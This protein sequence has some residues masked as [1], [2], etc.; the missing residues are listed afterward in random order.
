[1]RRILPAVAFLATATVCPAPATTQALPDHL[2]EG[3]FEVLVPNLGAITVPVLVDTAQTVLIPLEPL[4][5]HVGYSVELQPGRSVWRAAEAAPENRLLLDPPRF[6]GADGRTSTLSDAAVAAVNDEVYVSTEALAT[7]LDAEVEVDWGALRVVVSRQEPPFPAQARARIEERRRR[8]FT[9]TAAGSGPVVPYEARSGGVIFDWNIGTSPTEERTL[10]RGAVG[11]AVL[12]GDLVVGGSVAMGRAP[13]RTAEVSY[14]RIFPERRWVNQL[15]LGQVVTQDMAPRSLAGV[16]V[17]NIP[18]QRDAQFAHVPVAPDIPEGWEFEVYQSGRLIGFSSAGADDAV[19]VPVR[20]GQTPLEVRMVG[21]SGQEVVSQ[22]RYMVPISHLPPERLEYSA[23]AGVC[24][25]DRCD[26]LGY[27]EVRYGL[28]RRLTVGGGFQAVSEDGQ[29]SLRPSALASFVPDRHWALEMEARAEEFV[30]ASVDRL[31][32]DGRHVGLDASLHQPVFG[33]P[34]FFLGSDTRWQIQAQAGLHP[35]H[36]SARLDGMTGK[37]AE[38]VRV[39][40]GRSIPRGFGELALEVGDFGE[41]RMTGRATTILPERW[42][43][44]ERPVALSGSFSTSTDGLRL[45]E[46]SSSLRPGADSY[47]STAVQWNGERNEFHLTVTFR[48]LLEAARIDVAAARRTTNST[49]TLS[50]NGSIAFDGARRVHFTDR[51]LQGRAGVVG[52]VYYDRD[53]D[54]AFGDADDPAPDISVLVGGVRTQ[55]DDDG[56]Y[57]AWNVTPYEVTA[58][59]VDTLSGIDPRYTVLAGGTLLRPVPHLPNRVDFPLAETREL[60]GQVIQ[61]GGGGVGGV[62]VELIHDDTGRRQSVRTFS[63]GTFYVSRLLPGVWTIRIAAPSLEALQ[64]TSDPEAVVLD[65]NVA[66]TQ[67][68][69]ELEPFVLEALEGDPTQP[70]R[71][72]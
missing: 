42:W 36:V 30:R 4:L 1:M 55:T 24:P 11:G 18:Q 17:S 72:R 54:H 45:L 15:L 28:D 13:D 66:D 9:P 21:P 3:L 12:G 27:G 35:L 63:D 52:R 69:I 16:V 70:T 34:S 62:E 46:V 6:M 29:F 31:S 5:G 71:D 2:E 61:P 38:R 25:R 43:A 10:F 53:G 32:D 44:F 50:A 14:R 51:D 39:G 65:I 8:L 33:Q 26:G 19:L 49:L 68:L 64:T 20:Y 22:Y 60:L 56:F 47:L 7:I 37:G 48:Q 58:V 40:V 23:G 41:N 67:P 59:A 57:R